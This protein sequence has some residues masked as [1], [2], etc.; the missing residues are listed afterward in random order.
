MRQ[1]FYSYSEKTESFIF[2]RDDAFYEFTALKVPL[3]FQYSLGGMRVV[4]FVN[5]GVGA[6]VLLQDDYIHIR[7]SE[8]ENYGKPAVYITEDRKLTFA[9]YELSGIAGAGIKLRLI[10]T[11]NLRIEGRIEF[12]AGPLQNDNSVFKQ[13]STQQSVLLGISF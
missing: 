3:M 9:P 11:I 10:N 13:S 2:I 6:M 7:E 5:G 12:G 8:W 4:P 1:T